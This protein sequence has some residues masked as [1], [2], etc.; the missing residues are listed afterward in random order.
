MNKIYIGDNEITTGGGGGSADLTNY[1]NKQQI[2]AS[3]GVIDSSLKSF[4]ASIKELA[5]S[6][7]GGGSAPDLTNY[8][9]KSD[10]STFKP[11]VYTDM[12]TYEEDVSNGDIDES[13]MYV[14]TDLASSED[15]ATLVTIDDFN[16]EKAR[17]NASLNE[18][19]DAIISAANTS[20]GYWKDQN[21][22]QCQSQCTAAKNSALNAVQNQ[23]TTSINAVNSAAA[24][25][26]AEMPTF[27]VCTESEYNNLSTKD[28]STIYFIKED[29]V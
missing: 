16:A 23:Q 29:D 27:L 17:I 12:N 1:Y 18:T 4:D 26:I 20:C 13:A 2:D 8:A 7:G 14:I 19:A 21:V 5:T 9:T 22:S 24:T 3:Y 6:G 28:P 15:L 25:R 11:I 10:I